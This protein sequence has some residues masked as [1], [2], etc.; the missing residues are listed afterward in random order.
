M[1]NNIRIKCL[2]KNKN[3]TQTSLVIFNY[4]MF[5]TYIT[6]KQTPIYPPLRLN[7]VF[8]VFFFIAVPDAAEFSNYSSFPLLRCNDHIEVVVSHV[9]VLTWVNLAFTKHVYSQKLL[10]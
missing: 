5:Q 7:T 1:Q 10:M 4:E 2:A 9:H 8:T 6:I 3:K